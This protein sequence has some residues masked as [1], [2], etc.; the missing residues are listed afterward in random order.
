[1]TAGPCGPLLRGLA[2]LLAII[3]GESVNGTIRELLITPSLG[4]LAARRVSFVTALLMISVITI[5]TIRWIRA[6]GYRQTMLVGLLW[7]ILEVALGRFVTGASWDRI[8]Q[9]YDIT[10]GG[11]M[12]FGSIYLLLVPSIAFC[13]R[14]RSW[15]AR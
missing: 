3:A 5:F 15:Q 12:L 7:V 11:L 2:V 8:V 4:D 10:R 14:R 1:M 9:D 13:I 6:A